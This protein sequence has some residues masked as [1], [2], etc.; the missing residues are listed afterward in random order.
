MGRGRRRSG[1][2]RRGVEVVGLWGLGGR[3]RRRVIT[4]VAVVVGAVAVA[5]VVVEE[6]PG[7]VEVVRRP[8]VEEVEVAAAL[9]LAPAR[10]TNKSYNPQTSREEALLGTTSQA[11]TSSK[12]M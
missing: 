2:L 4:L 12:S 9:V 8:E 1:R 7:K 5:V 6:V 11:S 3:R 10:G